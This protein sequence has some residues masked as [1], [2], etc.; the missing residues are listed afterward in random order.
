VL[1]DMP[2]VRLDAT[3]A[4]KQVYDKW[5][6]ADEY[7]LTRMRAAQVTP[8]PVAGA[9]RMTDDD[10]EHVLRLDREVFGAGRRAVLDHLRASAPQ[11]AWV[12]EAAGEIAGFVLGRPGLRA[13]HAGPLVARDAAMAWTLASACL[14]ARPAR[15]WLLDAPDHDAAWRNRLEAA[16]F[17]AERPFLRMF[18]GRRPEWGR[19][20]AQ[21]AIAGPEFG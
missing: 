6:F 16:G 14:G 10:Y 4:G 19:P 20:Q 5:G 12:V 15:P 8:G 9:R 7:G 13:E 21:F 18:R 1:D 11:Y 3:P 2:C 17:H